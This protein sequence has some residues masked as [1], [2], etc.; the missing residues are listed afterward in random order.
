LEIRETYLYFR[1][2]NIYEDWE[3]IKI[4][5]FVC[6]NFLSKKK[7]HKTE[8][9]YVSD[10]QTTD[11][12]YIAE[13]IRSHWHIE[14]KLHYTKDVSQK[15]KQKSKQPVFVPCSLLFYLKTSVLHPA[16]S[17]ITSVPPL[18]VFFCCFG[19]DLLDETKSGLR[20][21]QFFFTK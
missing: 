20:S 11:A 1:E 6:R 10:L 21:L 19:R 17:H 8:S 13:G 4:I 2:N 15:N 9:I 7:E 12:A 5:A 3:S 16:H 14:N 18:C